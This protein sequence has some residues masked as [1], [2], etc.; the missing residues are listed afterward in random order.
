MRIPLASE[1][2]PQPDWRFDPIR[3]ADITTSCPTCGA[4][5]RLDEATV[6]QTNAEVVYT[7]R[8]GCGPILKVTEA[9]PFMGK[10]GY[11]L[12]DWMIRNPQVV[13]VKIRGTQSL[14]LPAP[15]P[16]QDF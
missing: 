12:G 8:E 6:T 7:C 13:I 3:E 11:R 16:L 2:L 1:V 10:G 4:Q 14:L 5:Q 15:E 9:K